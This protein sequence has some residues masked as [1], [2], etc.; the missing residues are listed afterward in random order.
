MVASKD[1]GGHGLSSAE[2]AELVELAE[3]R[4]W[5]SM[6]R[7]IPTAAAEALGIQVVAH[8]AATALAM[9][10]APS[11]LVN[12]VLALGVGEPATERVLD[13]MLALYRAIG[14]ERFAVQ[15]AAEVGPSELPAWLAERDLVPGGHWAKTFRGNGPLSTRPAGV[16]VER[17][18]ESDADTFGQVGMQGF[19]MPEAF[20]P[21]FAG[22]VGKPGWH[23]YL[24][25]DGPVPIATG[26]MYVQGDVAWL[27]MGSTM[28]DH[29]RRGAQGSLLGRRVEDG[30][31]LGC[32]WF[33]TE[34]GAEDPDRPNASLRNML[35]TGFEVA[36]LRTNYAPRV[37]S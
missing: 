4:A 16:R 33:V 21:L 19:E 34:T 36:Y 32:R 18:A 14:V 20:A 6:Y 5:A 9:A 13:E 31:E 1:E 37:G 28:P 23:A 15:I 35:R 11:P 8:G 26:A 25:Y 3:A 12:R 24:A 27:G 30:L 7:S 17:V 22:V 2:V 29:R 10:A